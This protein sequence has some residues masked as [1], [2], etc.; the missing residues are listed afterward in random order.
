MAAGLGAAVFPRHIAVMD[1]YLLK[2]DPANPKLT[3]RVS[4]IDHQGKTVDTSV[5]VERPLTL[6]L[7]GQ[8]IV[9]MMIW[10]SAIC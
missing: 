8:E 9:T 2:P 3:E 7:N 6:Y 5:V 4:G 1:G 10:R